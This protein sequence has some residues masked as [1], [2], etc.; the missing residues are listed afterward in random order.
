MS[1]RFVSLS[2][3]ADNY[4]PEFDEASGSPS[5]RLPIHVR[6]ENGTEYTYYWDGR[7]SQGKKYMVQL[8]HISS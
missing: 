4:A 6:D 1:T 7:S 2:L 5:G 8:A 3:G